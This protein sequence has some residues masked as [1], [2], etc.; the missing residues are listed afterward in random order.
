MCII[1]KTEITDKERYQ[2]IHGY[3]KIIIIFIILLDYIWSKINKFTVFYYV[4]NEGYYLYY[5]YV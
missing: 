1:L 2:P 4:D 5:L 3:N